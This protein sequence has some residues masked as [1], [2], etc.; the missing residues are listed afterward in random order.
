VRIVS[1]KLAFLSEHPDDYDILFVGSSRVYRQISPATFD[2][3]LGEAGYPLRSFNLGIGA[4]KV[5]EVAFLLKRLANEQTIRPRYIFI[6]PD[7]LLAT[8][9][10][11]N[12]NRQREIYWHERP[13]TALAIRSLDD[14]DRF[15]RANYVH[16]HARAH[17]FNILGYG[18]LR[19]FLAGA[20][21]TATENRRILG[22]QGDGF[23]PYTARSADRFELERREFFLANLER[24][25]RGVAGWERRQARRNQLRPQHIALF[26]QLKRN[27]ERTRAEPIFILSPVVQS[28]GEAREAHLRG[29]LPV[30]LAFDDPNLYPQLFEVDHRFDLT[31]LNRR[32]AVLYSELLAQ[33]F[34]DHL[35]R[36]RVRSN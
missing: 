1:E 7:G 32:G 3:V 12:T 34:A 22:K 18:R 30:L 25:H 16:R 4:A 26:E 28:R 14:E 10:E 2:R 8:I 19:G 20:L 36:S 33:R 13:E 9:A 27:I 6:D 23:L 21:D 17:I 35:D 5:P 11:V 29:V 31:H 24:Y 15:D